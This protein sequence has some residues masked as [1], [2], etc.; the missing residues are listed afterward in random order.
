MTLLDAVHLY[1]HIP[2]CRYRCDYC[3]FFTRTRVPAYR[4][5]QVLQAIGDHA[6]EMLL[7]FGA[8]SLKTVYVG[9]G[10]PTSLAPE[11]MAILYEVLRRLGPA[12]ETTVE[13]NPEDLSEELLDRLA[14]SGVNRLSVGIQS[15]DAD[16]LRTIGRHTTL[17]RTRSGLK[18]L[19]A[20]W[21]DASG[22]QRRWS[23]DLIVGIPGR[24]AATI[25]DEIYTIA[26][27]GPDHLSVYE[28]SVEPGTTL[29]HRL[30]QGL[31]AATDPHRVE[32]E[33]QEVREALTTLGY[34]H[35]EV[36]SF[37]RPGGESRHN[38]GYWEMQ[39]HIGVGPGATGTIPEPAYQRHTN[40]R[41][42]RLYLETRDRGLREEGLSRRV[43]LKEIL[44]MGLRTVYGVS[45]Q[46]IRSL[47]GASL[48][49]VIPQT[50]SRWNLNATGTGESE[51]AE[52]FRYRLAAE[53]RLVLDRF[54]REAF[55]EIDR[56]PPF[57]DES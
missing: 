8:P 38:R 20:H 49:D 30:R 39:P 45:A 7:R 37:A 17:E 55:F 11:A 43:L 32:D 9:G 41:D 6:E 48:D 15:L 36:S 23:A 53:Q 19:A 31:A 47:A 14:E 10:T 24:T 5:R 57:P 13:V 54:L 52:G 46:R 29:G 28:L 33:L 12:P 50:L 51:V 4:Q 1:L 26:A 27:C 21:R 56:F 22:S 35:Y 3:D 34:H 42:F 44:M 25:M 2:F 18:L 16:A 40:T